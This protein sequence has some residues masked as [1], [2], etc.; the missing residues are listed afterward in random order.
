MNFGVYVPFQSNVFLWIYAQ[1]WDCWTIW[2][3][4]F[5]FLK[6]PPYFSPQW[7]YL[8]TFPSV[9]YP[10]SPFS[11][12]SPAFVICRLFNDGHSDLCDVVPHSSFDLH[13]MTLKKKNLWHIEQDHESQCSAW[14][15]LCGTCSVR[16]R[17]LTSKERRTQ[18]NK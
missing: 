3:L 16:L 11:I 2:Q 5:Q 9:M 1:E 13:E 4:Y 8:F 7:L 17:G 10:G 6:E 18:E 12:P 15:L 14:F